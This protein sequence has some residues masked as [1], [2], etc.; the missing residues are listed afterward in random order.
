MRGNMAQKSHFLLSD[1]E[2][3]FFFFFFVRRC[4][5]VQRK[6]LQK[7]EM[8][9]PLQKLNVPYMALQ[10]GCFVAAVESPGEENLHSL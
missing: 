5:T 3:Y 2:L 9:K 4:L 7:A 1:G 10:E 8:H 6:E